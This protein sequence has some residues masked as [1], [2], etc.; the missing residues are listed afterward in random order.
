MPTIENAF[1]DFTLV[2][3]ANNLLE[4]ATYETLAKIEPDLWEVK[5]AFH[6]GKEAVAIYYRGA[7]FHHQYNFEQSGVKNM[8]LSAIIY[9][10]AYVITEGKEELLTRNDLEGLNVL[11]RK[12]IL[13]LE[14]NDEGRAQAWADQKFSD[15]VLAADE[16]YHGFMGFMMDSLRKW[17]SSNG[18]IITQRMLW[19]IQSTGFTVTAKHEDDKI[20]FNRKYE[21]LSDFTTPM[22]QVVKD[23]T[24]LLLTMGWISASPEPIDIERLR[25]ERLARNFA[26][27]HQHN[28]EQNLKHSTLT[29][30]CRTAE[31]FADLPP[32]M[33]ELA[34]D[35]E[36]GGM[37]QLQSRRDILSA[38]GELEARTDISDSERNEKMAALYDQLER[39]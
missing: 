14:L 2:S 32:A 35:T 19:G 33:Q 25:K 29:S 21:M 15:P 26:H 5:R 7:L 18:V 30:D 9:A 11:A 4:G 24:T 37:A 39:M 8:P 23:F 3:P 6:N 12:V 22:Q 1:P 34:G 13:L 28:V 16:L 27:N 31:S 17:K 36:L 20:E 38:L 10:Q